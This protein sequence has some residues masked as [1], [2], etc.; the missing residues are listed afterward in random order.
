MFGASNRGIYF[1]AAVVPALVGL[2]V[3]FLSPAS[4]EAVSG[5]L[6][7][8]GGSG[9]SSDNPAP[10]TLPPVS[11]IRCSLLPLSHTNNPRHH[12]RYALFLACWPEGAPKPA[13]PNNLL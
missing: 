10:Y 4:L 1:A 11:N 3:L 2:L 13:P 12:S 8:P 5:A 6:F 9:S 7:P